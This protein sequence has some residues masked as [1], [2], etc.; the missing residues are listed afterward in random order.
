MLDVNAALADMKELIEWADLIPQQDEHAPTQLRVQ[1]YACIVR[2]SPPGSVYREMA[3][4]ANESLTVNPVVFVGILKALEMDMRF[5]K[6]KTFEELI[7]ADVYSDLIAQAEGLQR[8]GYSR[9]AM[10]VGGA[11][12]EG[13]LRKLAVKNRIAVMTDRGDHKKA[14]Q[15]NT[16]MKVAGLYN[17]AQRAIVEGWQKLRN[18]AA[19]GSPGFEPPETGHVGSVG[20]AIVGIRHFIV[21]Y[22]A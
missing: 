19:H 16:E 8:D 15:L 21:Q 2:N 20:P 1:L 14:S 13:H 4:R 17:E 3:D 5:D 22:P 9:A 10:V 11:A 7:H 6:L 18:D 12:L